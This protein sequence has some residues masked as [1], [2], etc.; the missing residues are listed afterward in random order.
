MAM[1]GI[2]FYLNE[3]TPGKSAFQI[4]DE[5]CFSK[6]GLLTFEYNNLY[7]SLF[8]KS[9][10]LTMITTFGTVPN[11]NSTGLIQNEGNNGRSV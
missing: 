5:A 3:V 11:I 7:N 2:P 6:G 4:I 1:G 9:V 10:F 8:S